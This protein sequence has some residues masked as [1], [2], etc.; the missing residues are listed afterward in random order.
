ML[1][2]YDSQFPTLKFQSLDHGKD[3][4]NMRT[5]LLNQRNLINPDKTTDNWSQIAYVQHENYVPSSEWNWLGC[6]YTISSTTSAVRNNLEFQQLVITFPMQR[7]DP[8]H[9]MT[10]FVPALIL[11]ILAPLG[12]I[13]PGDDY[14]IFQIYG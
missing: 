3:I 8:F 7:H 11:T 13:L 6:H 2:P 12:L 1:Y 10:L 5:R 14:I 4:I 9:T